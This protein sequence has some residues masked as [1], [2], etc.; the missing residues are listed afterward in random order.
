MFY[1]VQYIINSFFKSVA[2]QKLFIMLLQMY[3][4]KIMIIVYNTNAIDEIINI[5]ASCI[6]II[7]QNEF[8]LDVS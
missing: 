1:S 8:R 6:K 5:G 7:P 3:I 2:F 4:D